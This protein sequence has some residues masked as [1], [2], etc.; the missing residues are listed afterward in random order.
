MF[1]TTRNTTTHL[2]PLTGAYS[3]PEVQETIARLQRLVRSDE[4]ASDLSMRGESMVRSSGRFERSRILAT[5]LNGSICRA[6]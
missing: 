3:N 6:P 1:G 4:D 5:W 2:V